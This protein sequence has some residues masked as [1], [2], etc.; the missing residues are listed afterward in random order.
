M[1]IKQR[2]TDPDKGYRMGNA[3]EQK[4]ISANNV[5][6]FDEES[7]SLKEESM[8]LIWDSKDKLFRSACTFDVSFIIK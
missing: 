6:N 2:K 1:E 3:R 8:N 7:E 5:Y 4:V